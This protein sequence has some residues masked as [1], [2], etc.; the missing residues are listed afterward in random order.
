MLISHTPEGLL[1]S[2]SI[3]KIKMIIFLGFG[4]GAD[5]KREI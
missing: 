4:Y 2:L 3:E 1:K 5:I